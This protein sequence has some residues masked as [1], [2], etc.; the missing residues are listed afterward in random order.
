MVHA[1]ISKNDQ[2]HNL[3]RTKVIWQR[4]LFHYIHQWCNSI[5]FWRRCST[6]QW[7][8]VNSNGRGNG[9]L[10]MFSWERIKHWALVEFPRGQIF[11]ATDVNLGMLVGKNAWMKMDEMHIY[12]YTKL[13]IYLSSI[14]Y[15]KRDKISNKSVSKIV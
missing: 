4:G 7:S 2:R 10:S 8:M 15:C 14:I 13:S 6:D 9:L 11:Y 1:I 5:Q 3:K 12:T